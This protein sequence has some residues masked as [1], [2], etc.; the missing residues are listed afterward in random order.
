MNKFKLISLLFLLACVKYPYANTIDIHAADFSFTPDTVN[1]TVGDTIKWVWVNG[2]H[3]TTSTS[4]PPGT[5]AWSS[6]LDVSNTSFIYVLTVP[7]TYNF[8]CNF[9]FTIGMTGVIL[10]NPIGIIP[11]SNNIPAKFSLYQNYPNPFNPST[12]IKFDLPKKSQVQIDIFDAKGSKVSSLVNDVLEAGTYS[13]D[14][15]ASHNASG[16]YYYKVSAGQ[17]SESKKMIL[18]K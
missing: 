16:V 13:I 4:V 3:S 9:H 5:S 6:P 12:N 1:A 18:L 10:A 17:F 15:D 8:Q 7:G 11:I 14:W 2:T